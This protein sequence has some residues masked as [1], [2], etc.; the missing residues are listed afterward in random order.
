[1]Y[2]YGGGASLSYLLDE[3]EEDVLVVDVEEVFLLC[4]C[5]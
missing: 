5:E 1:M 2:V 3:E 4:E